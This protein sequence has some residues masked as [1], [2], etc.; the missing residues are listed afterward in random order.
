MTLWK[1]RRHSP[2]TASSEVTEPDVV[3]KPMFAILGK[4]AEISSLDSSKPESL[5][6]VHPSTEAAFERLRQEKSQ[7]QAGIQGWTRD[8]RPLHPS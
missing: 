5:Y 6:L 4:K 3:A 2:T 7:V 1:R 8:P